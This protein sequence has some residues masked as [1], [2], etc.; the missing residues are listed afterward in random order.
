MSDSS[1]ELSGG[2]TFVNEAKDCKFIIGKNNIY[3]NIIE[4]D[5]NNDYILACQVV[6]KKL[7]LSFLNFDLSGDYTTYS[8]YIKDSL[9]Q[10]YYRSRNEILSDSTIYKVF[11][12]RNVTFDNSLEDI[13]KG[14]E[15]ADSVIKN[16]PMHKKILSLK[17]VYWIIKIKGNVLIGPL[18]DN[19][20][21]T[22]RKE[23]N[24]SEELKL[25]K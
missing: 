20:F 3:P 15:I 17:K 9:S 11:K 5:F 14:E 2:Y 22:K 12:N 23:L 1:E 18:S 24:I 13:K 10:K 19:E 21:K 16:N 8:S 7:Y 6:N 25:I 4:Y